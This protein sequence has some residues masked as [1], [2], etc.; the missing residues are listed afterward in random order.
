ME[1]RADS[2]RGLPVPGWLLPLQVS[3]GLACHPAKGPGE[4]SPSALLSISKSWA[5]RSG[6][7]LTLRRGGQM[8]V[9]RPRNPGEGQLR[10]KLSPDTASVWGPINLSQIRGPVQSGR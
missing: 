2:E 1:G 6:S 4:L 8:R 3:D 5:P 10:G 9:C 7:S